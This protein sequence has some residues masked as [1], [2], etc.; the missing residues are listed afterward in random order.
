MYERLIQPRWE[1]EDAPDYFTAAEYA[2]GYDDVTFSKPAGTETWYAQLNYQTTSKEYIEFLRDEINGD[3]NTLPDSAYIIQ[4]DPF[5]ANLKGWGNA[6]YDLWLHN[7]GAAPV[8]MAA[9]GDVPPPSCD[10]EVPQNLVAEEE[11]NRIILTWEPVEDAEGYYI[12][13]K[14]D[15][16][17]VLING[18]IGTVINLTELAPN[19]E[20]CFVVTAFKTCEPGIS[21]ESAYSNEVCAT[22][23]FVDYEIELGPILDE[24]GKPVKSA[25]VEVEINGET[26]I[27]QTDENG[28]VSFD[29]E[30]KPP[31][32]NF[33]V[34]VTKENFEN[35]SYEISIDLKGDEVQAAI[36]P[37]V[38][39]KTLEDD[40]LLINVAILVVLGI[41]LMMLVLYSRQKTEVVDIDFE[42]E[43]R[44]AGRFNCPAC[45]NRVRNTDKVCDKCGEELEEKVV[46][47]TQCG[48][49]FEEGANTC[50]TCGAP[51]PGKSQH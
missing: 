4:S 12:Y 32:G 6:M 17:F 42:K 9:V 2:G 49:V 15:E 26:L 41:L 51:F 21:G 8:E 1:G 38:K 23:I 44:P 29:L 45:K 43:D 25:T 31:T 18:V 14:Q 47:C 11:E 46:N 35:I 34:M 36:P 39:I 30:S 33:T 3:G 13:Q 20:H 40:N 19:Q 22:F 37:L 10:I 5:F 28:Q 27:D 48:T 50:E 24:D 16:K 7:G